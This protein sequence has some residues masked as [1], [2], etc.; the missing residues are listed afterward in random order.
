M[1]VQVSA[2]AARAAWGPYTPAAAAACSGAV[3]IISPCDLDARRAI[4]GNTRWNGYL[5]HVTETCDAAVRVNLIPDI[6]TISPIRDTQALPGIHTRLRDRRLLP[7]QHLVDGGYIPTALLNNSAR[8]DRIQ[9]VA[10][11][12]ASGAWQ[13]KEQTGFTRDDFTI[14]FDQRQVTCPNGRTSTTWIEAPAMTPYT[15]VR[16]AV[17]CARAEVSRWRP[18]CGRSPKGPP[19]ASGGEPPSPSLALDVPA[20]WHRSGAKSG[21]YHQQTKNLLGRTRPTRRQAQR[22]VLVPQCR[23]AKPGRRIS[24]VAYRA[25]ALSRSAP[26]CPSSTERSQHQASTGGVSTGDDVGFQSAPNQHGSQH[27][28]VKSP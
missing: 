17:L 2:A 26:R 3:R 13:K 23:A 10:P 15:V 18:P 8:D 24:Q 4:R 9:L 1:S 28:T 12:K 14:D 5:V 22:L 25:M 19:R 21:V 27:R 7:A 11:V 20:L 6:A 16:F